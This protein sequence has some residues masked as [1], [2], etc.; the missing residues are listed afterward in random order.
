VE[1][2]FTFIDGNACWVCV[3]V[4]F[5]WIA[6]Q[7]REEMQRK[8]TEIETGA[9]SDQ[10][11]ASRAFNQK[12]LPSA[13]PTAAVSAHLAF[14]HHRPNHHTF[15]FHSLFFAKSIFFWTQKQG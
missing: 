10:L 6:L 2:A 14:H 13:P 11:D 1:I 8:I 3:C 12:P 4:F 9:P 15:T 7:L 5:Y